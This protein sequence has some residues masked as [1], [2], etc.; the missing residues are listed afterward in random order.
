MKFSH[1]LET[2]IRATKAAG[3]IQMKY[4]GKP[5]EKKMKEKNDFATQADFESEKAIIKILQKEFPDYGILSEEK[6][7]TKGNSDYHWIVDPLDGTVCY[8]YGFPFFGVLIALEKKQKLELGV[9]YQ[10]V[11]NEALAAQ[12]NKGCF[13][14]GKKVQVSKRAE[15]QEAFLGYNGIRDQLKKYPEQFRN[16]LNA[17]NWRTGVPS[18]QGTISLCSGQLDIF[19]QS[20]GKYRIM[21]PWDTAAPK[22]TIEEAGGVFSNYRGEKELDKIDFW[23][24]TN[25][26]LHSKVIQILNPKKETP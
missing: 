20:T 17:A 4:F 16:L 25:Q 12:R 23:L 15:L 11:Q 26:K 14:N 3:K 1:E 10:T 6:G 19:L 8:S 18:L 13:L 21:K 2:A 24:A 22:I 7:E 5:L 9:V